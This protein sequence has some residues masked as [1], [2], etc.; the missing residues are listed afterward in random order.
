MCT[1]EDLCVVK[2]VAARLRGFGFPAPRVAVLV[3]VAGLELSSVASGHPPD[4][5][6]NSPERFAVWRRVENDGLNCL[7]LQLS[8]LGY[9]R[10]Y[11]AYLKEAG[12]H[13]PLEDLGALAF[14]AGKLG[15]GVAPARLTMEE[16]EGATVPVVVHL[17]K[18][19][20]RTGYFVLVLGFSKHSVNVIHGATATVEHLPRDTFRREWSSY[21]LVPQG[22]IGGVSLARRVL[23]ALMVAWAVVCVGRKMRREKRC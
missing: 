5:Q 4:D 23:A 13:A 8:M 1:Y 3:L 18:H 19:E 14:V 9:S 16:L 15:I 7:F 11:E 22:G 21:A 17:E 12:E 20:R 10:P 2:T 6:G